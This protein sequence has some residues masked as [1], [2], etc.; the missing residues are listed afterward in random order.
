MYHGS[1]PDA[2]KTET[3]FTVA[4]YQHLLIA[5][6]RYGIERLKKNCED[7]L[8]VNGIT[9]DSVV[10]MLELAEDHA[11]S[12]LKARCLDFPADANNFKIVGTSGEYIC[13][14]QSFPYLLVEVQ[15]RIKMAP[16]KST[17]M[18]PGAHKK[19]RGMVMGYMKP[20]P[21]FIILFIVFTGIFLFLV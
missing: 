10:S 11:C 14:M 7:K 8:S 20:C 12:K 17:I 21:S 13:L 6:D 1:L 4:G 18:S 3:S 19:S 5:A 9:V 15:N 2:G 16:A